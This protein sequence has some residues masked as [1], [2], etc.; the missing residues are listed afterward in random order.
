MAPKKKKQ[1]NIA[2]DQTVETQ[3]DDEISAVS[4]TSSKRGPFGSA[5]SAQASSIPAPAISDT[6]LI[7]QYVQT[8]MRDNQIILVLDLFFFLFF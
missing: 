5:F 4:S 8:L 1:T 2:T 3:N 6:A 7:L